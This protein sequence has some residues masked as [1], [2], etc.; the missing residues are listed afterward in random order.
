MNI[1]RTIRLW[2]IGAC[3]VGCILILLPL[4]IGG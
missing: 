1:G 3:I 2:V 4:V